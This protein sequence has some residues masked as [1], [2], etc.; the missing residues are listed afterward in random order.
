MEVNGNVDVVTELLAISS[1]V[2]DGPI[3][4]RVGLNPLVGLIGKTYFKAGHTGRKSC[5]AQLGEVF[6]CSCILG[7]VIA[8]DTAV[9]VRPGK[10]LLSR[11]AQ[12][13]AANIPECLIDARSG[14]SDYRASAIEAVDVH[15]FPMMFHLQGVFADDEIPEVLH[16]GHGGAGLAFKSGFTPADQ[17]LIGFN[18]DEDIR[19]VGV[20]S[21][22]DA[23]YLH[24]CDAQIEAALSRPGSSGSKSFIGMCRLADQTIQ[25]LHVGVGQ[26]PAFAV[27]RNTGASHLVAMVARVWSVT[28][29]DRLVLFDLPWHVYF[30][31]SIENPNPGGHP[32][33]G[34]SAETEL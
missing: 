31:T 8:A 18:L 32:R 1:H 28:E 25:G 34:F 15:R 20:G 29:F 2:L 26:R 17:A 11:D 21:Q 10:K 14:R 19:T 24:V 12:R 3:N 5:L 22:R 16:A 23:E 13:F 4:L 9:F 30:L 6:I 7:M 27:S 33:L